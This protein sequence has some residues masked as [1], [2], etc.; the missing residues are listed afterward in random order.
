MDLIAFSTAPMEEQRQGLAELQEIVRNSPQVRAAEQQG[1]LIRLPTGDGMA[2]V[3]FGDPIA[4]IECALHISA[5]LQ[6]SRLKLRMG[7]NTGPV[8]RV[9]DINTNLNAAGGG[10]NTAQRIMDAGDAGHILVS[11]TTSEILLQLK[12]WAGYL[13]DLG[14]HPVK[15]G[16]NL[17]FYNLYTAELGNAALP[18][19]FQAELAQAAGRQKRRI[20]MAAAL[21]LLVAIGIASA[22]RMLP[23][24]R[25][26]S[27]VVI[28][29]RNI[30]ARQ[31]RD[32]V[33][34]ELAEGLRA[35]LIS[36]GKVRVISGEESAEMRRDLGRS[37]QT[38]GLKRSRPETAP[39]RQQIDSLSGPPRRFQPPPHLLVNGRFAHLSPRAS[40]AP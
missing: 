37:P 32:W 16:K 5:Q 15:H 40:G 33:P 23:G 24:G 3:F 36:T 12:D 31:D 8:Y 2:L 29:F 28:G 19:K 38:S 26:R 6:T 27:V 11:K 34:A 39:A 35:Q 9:S 22:M 1:E 4:C 18:A 10:I 30:N 7:I 20:A 14:E 17:Q 25:R 13:H 21:A